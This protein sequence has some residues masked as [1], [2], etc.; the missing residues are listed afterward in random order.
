ML[1][2][3]PIFIWLSSDPVATDIASHGAAR[4][5]VRADDVSAN[6][7]SGHNAHPEI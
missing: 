4:A 3:Q 6:G 2:R 5:A 7:T 1:L